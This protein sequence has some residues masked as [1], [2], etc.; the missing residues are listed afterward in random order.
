[1]I[2]G[3]AVALHIRSLLMM[4]EF[5]ARLLYYFAPMLVPQKNHPGLNSSSSLS[6]TESMVNRAA[7]LIGLIVVASA[8]FGPATTGRAEPAPAERKPQRRIG[9]VRVQDHALVD[10][11]GPFL[12]LGVSYFTALWRCHHDRARLESD[13]R[14]LSGQGFNYYRMLSMVG[15]HHAWDGLEIALVAFTNR[16]GKGVVAWPDY[17]KQLPD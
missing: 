2:H 8:S 3:A 6:V 10:D 12:G 7:T 9:Q 4:V 17:W 11:S 13:L 5:A 1:V 16:A 15:W 14:F